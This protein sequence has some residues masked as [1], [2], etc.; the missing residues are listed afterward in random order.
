MDVLPSKG[1]ISQSQRVSS[2]VSLLTI[3]DNPHILDKTIDDH[4]NL[5]CGDPTLVQGRVDPAFPASSDR[6][7]LQRAS[8]Q[9]SLSCVES[10]KMPAMRYSPGCLCLTSLVAS[11]RMESSSDEGLHDC[12]R[13]SGCVRDLGTDVEAVSE[14][15]QLTGVYQQA[16]RV[17][18]RPWQSKSFGHQK[19]T[20]VGMKERDIQRVG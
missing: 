13:H 6:N 7:S 17:R 3:H 8:L 18:Q 12:L 1:R 20:H 11:P 19:N 4:K 10:D 9:M 16:D 5:R 14:R 2:R 15:T